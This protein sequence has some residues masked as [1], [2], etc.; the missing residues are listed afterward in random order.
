MRLLHR[1]TRR[2]SSPI[3]VPPIE[4]REKRGKHN[5]NNQLW[6]LNSDLTG[7]VNPKRLKPNLGFR[8]SW[9]M[10]GVISTENIIHQKLDYKQMACSFY[11]WRATERKQKRNLTA[12]LPWTTNPKVED[13]M[14]EV[15]DDSNKP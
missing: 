8:V 12:K 13:G 3:G 11:S 10:M 5:G 14:H 2:K 9:W 7:L 1:G 6:C 15:L 4:S